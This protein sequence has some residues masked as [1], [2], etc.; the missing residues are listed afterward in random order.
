MKKVLIFDF[1]GVFYS[2]K[3]KF[4]NV[5]EHVNKNRRKFLKELTDTQYEEVC[6][7]FPEW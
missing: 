7:K 4:D 3:H 5:A 1:D 6:K 2:G